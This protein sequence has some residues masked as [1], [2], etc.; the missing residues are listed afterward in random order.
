[1]ITCDY[2][3]LL[4]NIT[5]TAW[6][7]YICLTSVYTVAVMCQALFQADSEYEPIS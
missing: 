5:Q 3:G 1:M 7:V 4:V 6:I 2:P